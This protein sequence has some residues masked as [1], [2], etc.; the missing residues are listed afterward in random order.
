[1]NAIHNHIKTLDPSEDAFQFVRTSAMQGFVHLCSQGADRSQRLDALI[2]AM[3]A[4]PHG[5]SSDSLEHGQSTWQHY[6]ELCG[7]ISSGDPFPD[8]WPSWLA[9]HGQDLLA[10]QEP[11]STMMTYLTFHDCGKAWAL[12]RDVDGR[13]HYPD[14]AERSAEIWSRAGGSQRE[15]ELMRNDMALHTISADEA[16]SFAHNPLAPSLLLAAFAELQSNAT[17]IFGGRDSTSYKIKI[18]ALNRR[19]NAICRCLFQS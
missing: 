6:S 9:T 1:M 14:H 13:V 3:R 2:S 16:A 5:A 7:A 11:E 12:T 19:A 8:S 10:L 4:T 18:K 17:S 15:C